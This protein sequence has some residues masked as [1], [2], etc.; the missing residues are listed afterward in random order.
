MSLYGFGF[1]YDYFIHIPDFI[2]MVEH[3]NRIGYARLLHPLHVSMAKQRRHSLLQSQNQL[4][5]CPLEHGVYTNVINLDRYNLFL[6]GLTYIPFEA[7]LYGFL[8]A[9]QMSCFVLRY[10]MA[11]IKDV[12]L[13]WPRKPPDKGSDVSTT[14]AC[15]LIACSSTLIN[16]LDAVD[17]MYT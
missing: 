15:G 6:L 16:D 10:I 9:H 8:A 17:N 13:P 5:L 14:T 7:L 2:S 3:Y 1:L 4:L 12:C 11:A